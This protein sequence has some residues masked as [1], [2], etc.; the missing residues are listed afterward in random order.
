MTRSRDVMST[1]RST[2]LRTPTTDTAGAGPPAPPPAP[3]EIDRGAQLVADLLEA[4]E[5]LKPEQMQVVR[6]R[7]GPKGSVA[8]AILDGGFASPEGM[9]RI[10]A[11]RY[12]LP[13]VDLL[14]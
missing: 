6:D 5:L 2:Q 13:L 14:S 12:Q 10:L 3:F 7:A 1:E 8:Q 11:S 4:T 9:A